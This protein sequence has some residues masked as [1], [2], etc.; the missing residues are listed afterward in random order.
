M[1]AGRWLK[2]RWHRGHAQVRLSLPDRPG[3]RRGRFWCQ[4]GR[5]IWCTANGEPYRPSL[6]IDHANGDP[7]DN[8]LSNLRPRTARLN[9]SSRK[10]PTPPDSTT[11]TFRQLH[12]IALLLEEIDPVAGT[13]ISIPEIARRVGTT[14]RHV[15]RLLDGSRRAEDFCLA[16]LYVASGGAAFNA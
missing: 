7:T 3:A 4:L 16:R 6:D 1:T 12:R 9:R 2:P 14:D 8:R 11:I 15:R 13:A 5:L 10:S